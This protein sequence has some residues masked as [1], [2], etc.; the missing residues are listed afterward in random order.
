MST[1]ACV[2][3]AMSPPYWETMVFHPSK[4][5]HFGLFYNTFPPFVC[6]FF[7]TVCLLS[8]RCASRGK[9]ASLGR[10][11]R[12]E[13]RNLYSMR[14]SFQRASSFVEPRTPVALALG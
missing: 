14:S 3:R 5:T 12:L 11:E 10:S 2:I 1:E 9:R 7:L 6:A 13:K 4:E 8:S